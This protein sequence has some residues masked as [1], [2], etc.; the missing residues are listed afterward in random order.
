MLN[1]T[2]QNEPN[3]TYLQNLTATETTDHL[4]WRV[5]KSFN[6]PQMIIP[7]LGIK[8]GEW[9]KNDLQS[10]AEYFSEVVMFFHS[11]LNTEEEKEIIQR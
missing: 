3:K 7:P 10:F 8:E 9:V 2:K 11:E 4:L 5:T 6:H 1:D